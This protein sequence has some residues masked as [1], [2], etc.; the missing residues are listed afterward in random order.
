MAGL[1]T[2]HFNAANFEAL[3]L[4]SEE[5]VL[6]DF[7]ASWCG[8][9]RAIAPILDA[10]ADKYVG[11]A[12]IGKIDVDESSELALRFNVQSIPTLMVF[13]R[14]QLVEQVVGTA[15]LKQLAGLLDPH[16]ETSGQQRAG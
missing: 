12:R 15:S 14:G 6:V 3:V 13:V 8:P 7:W 5:P 16:L 10:L 4:G 1:N 9:C 11:R 2:Q